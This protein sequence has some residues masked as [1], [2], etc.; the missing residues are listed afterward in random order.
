MDHHDDRYIGFP[1][2]RDYCENDEEKTLFDKMHAGVSRSAQHLTSKKSISTPLY[3][4]TAGAAHNLNDVLRNNT[5]H[6]SLDSI[7]HYRT[8]HNQIQKDFAKAEPLNGVLHTYHGTTGNSFNYIHGSLKPGSR[9]KLLGYTSTTLD[10]GS[11]VSWG[12]H[13]KEVIHFHHES[14]G[15]HGVYIGYRSEYP[16]EKEFLINHGTEGVYEGTTVHDGIKIHHVR[17]GKDQ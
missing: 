3:E 6:L 10:P 4:Y 1:H 16:S 8:M 5:N 11:A 14:G 2:N 15:R 9:V 17:I 7:D 12:R 13:N